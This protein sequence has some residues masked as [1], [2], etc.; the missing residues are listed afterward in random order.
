MVDADVVAYVLLVATNAWTTVEPELGSNPLLWE[1]P[2][3][4]PTRAISYQS[5]F[6]CFDP[7]AA[8]STVCSL[9]PAHERTMRIDRDRI[10]TINSAIQSSY[11]LSV[12]FDE[13]SMA[14]LPPGISEEPTSPFYDNMIAT[15]EAKGRAEPAGMPPAPL[16]VSD[17][18]LVRELRYTP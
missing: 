5:N 2:A 9:T 12:R 13:A 14:F 11:P 16:E 3:E 4:L 7:A 18:D 17:S 1:A 15:L 6:G 10:H 8:S